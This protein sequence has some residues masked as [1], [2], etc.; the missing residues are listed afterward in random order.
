MGDA[1]RGFERDYTHFVLVDGAPI[2]YVVEVIST[3]L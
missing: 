2:V 3:I 1:R